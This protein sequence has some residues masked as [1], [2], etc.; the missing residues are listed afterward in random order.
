MIEYNKKE[1]LDILKE[2]DNLISSAKHLEEQNA[3]TLNLIHPENINS[4]CNLL[5]YIA[6]RAK[7]FRQ[8]Q[9]S[10]SNLA[11]SSIGHSESHTLGNLMKVKRLLLSI[12]G[13]ENK[14]LESEL[15]SQKNSTHYIKNN[16]A[17]LFGKTAFDGQ[18]KI[19]VTL[20]TEASTNYKLVFELV[21]N[22]MHVAR[23]NTAHDKKT[24]WK[25]MIDNIKKASKETGKKV[26]IYMD[27]EGPKI[28]TGAIK[29]LKNKIVKGKLKTPSIL[30]FSGSRIIL[31]KG[32]KADD[33]QGRVS[34]QLSLKE[35]FGQ[36]KPNESIWFD[37]GQLGGK[38]IAANNKEIEVE[39]THAPEEGF[40]L[41]SEK[42][43]NFPDSE[44]NISPLTI[45][46]LDNLKFIA[47]HADLVG[48]S[49]VQKPEEITTLQELLTGLKR[50]DI[51]IILKIETK[52][53]FENFPNL[54]FSALKFKN[55]GVMIARGD[56]AVE[57][58]YNRIA[59]LQEEILW[60][61][62]AAHV[63]V[64]WA[65]QVLETQI[66]KG[67]ATRA[68]ISDVV[69]AVRAECVMLNKGPFIIDALKTIKDI[70][71]LMA[72]HEDKKRKINRSLEVAM[73][74]V[75]ASVKKNAASK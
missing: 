14:D 24:D 44:I 42:G 63:P 50:E 46:D 10:L 13:E 48:F 15:I 21:K 37:D 18:S 66:K 17:T 39:I 1:I 59:E 64:I 49:F 16:S 29:P 9:K 30:L 22:G 12:I 31:T 6:I 75:D 2:V 26:R 47:K 23:I 60:F 8:L 28:R 58:G 45:E 68:E 74:F 3:Q 65:T 69:K 25:K 72:A 51:S 20:P 35:I 43:I 67:I 27:L 19:M 32:K 41:K 70:D 53:A 38:I 71:M 56:L 57:V 54:L 36:V 62:E 40:K 73:K 55:C 34:V 5:H 61:S 33:P 52:L 11:I 7:D 4:A